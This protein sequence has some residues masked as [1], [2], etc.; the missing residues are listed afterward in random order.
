MTDQIRSAGSQA[1]LTLHAKIIIAVIVAIAVVACVCTAWYVSN[2]NEQAAELAVQEE[3][4]RTYTV[5]V[6]LDVPGFDPATSTPVP[7]RIEGTDSEG[8]LVSQYVYLG[9]ANAETL[10]LACGKYSVSVMASPFLDD[11]T[12]FDDVNTVCD[13]TVTNTGVVSPE[14]AFTFSVTSPE[15]VTDD[16]ID[17]AAKCA[18]FAGVDADR[19]EE[20]SE[21][22]VE[23]RSQALAQI[24]AQQETGTV[25]ST[26]LAQI[27]AQPEAEIARNT[28]LAHFETDWYSFDLPDYWVDRVD[29]LSNGDVT[30]IYAKGTTVEPLVSFTMVDADQ[31]IVG[32]DIGHALVCFGEASNGKLLEVRDTN[33]SYLAIMTNYDRETNHAQNPSY[34]WLTDDVLDVSTGGA[35]TS[36]A[37]IGS[38][39]RSEAAIAT[40]DYIINN[41]MPSITI[42]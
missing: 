41:L 8:N 19:I 20:L 27:Q 13:F 30:V 35:Y 34:A 5:K 3:E 24:Q 29:V 33:I 39:P 28:Q 16:Q 42:K 10:E 11:G 21:R 37:A 25:Q 2:K 32:G 26:Q 18:T 38:D 1:G 40:H 22:A 14:P 23:R 12:V 6:A 36:I 7:L 9:T 31:P 4:H 17:R 15:N